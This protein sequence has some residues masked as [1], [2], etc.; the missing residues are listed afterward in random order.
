MFQDSTSGT[1]V[2]HVQPAEPQFPQ[3]EVVRHLLL[4][5]PAALRS[6]VKL[7]HA[8]HYADPNDWSRPLPT[9]RANEVMVILTKKV[10]LG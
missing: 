5:S 2:L 4:G 1:S 6:T 10:R 9:G 3:F 8:L 7:L